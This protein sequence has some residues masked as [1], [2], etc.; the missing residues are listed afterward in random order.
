MNSHPKEVVSLWQR[1]LSKGWDGSN[2]LSWHIVVDL[3][4]FTQ[5]ETEGIYDLLQTLLGMVEA[6]RNMMGKVI[7]R[8]V[9]AS[10]K[11]DDL[12]WRHIISD[13]DSEDT[14]DVMSYS[15]KLHCESH[16]FHKE[17]FLHKRLIDSENFLDLVITTLKNWAMRDVN[18]SALHGLRSTFMYSSS[19]ERRH[20]RRDIHHAD[21][22]SILLNGVENA[23]KY[24]ARLNDRWWLVN[25]PKLRGFPE[26]TIRYFLTKAYIENP[27]LNVVGI[28]GILTDKEMLRYGHIDYEIGELIVAGYHYLNN[29]EQESH[30][31]LVLGL[32][33][34]EDWGEEGVP[35][36]A[37]H[38]IYEYLIWIPAIFRLSQTQ[39]LIEQ[40]QKQFGVSRPEPHIHSWG[41]MVGSPVSLS[42]LM[43]LSD[44]EFFRLLNYYNDYQERSNHPADHLTGGRDMVERTL[45][46]L[47]AYDPIRYYDLIPELIMQGFQSGYLI[48][49]LRG[50]AEH[51]RYRFSRLQPPQGWEAIKPAPDGLFLARALICLL[52]KYSELWDDGHAVARILEVCCEVVE[53][54]YDTNRIVFLLYR[55]LEYS[56]PEEDKQVTFTQGKEENSDNDLRHTAIN[57]IRGIGAGSAIRLCNRLIEQDKDIPELMLPLL[58]HCARDPVLAVR[59]ALLDHLA[60]LTYK[61]HL[62]GWQLFRD[63]FREPQTY[64]WPLVESHLYH[65]YYEHFNDV[66]PYLNRMR[67]EVPVEAANSWAR[68]ITLATL[69]GHLDRNELF[70]QLKSVN[71]MTAW[72]GAAQ[73]FVANLDRY[74]EDGLCIYGLSHL[75]SL[76]EQSEQ[77]YRSIGHVFDLKNHSQYIDMAFA[78]KYIDAM[79]SGGRHHDLYEF[80]DWI[81]DLTGRDPVAALTVCEYLVEKL[82]D[83]ESSNQLWRTEPLISAL[84]GI[85]READETEDETLIHRAVNLQDRFLRMD[86]R[87]IEDFFEQAGH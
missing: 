69:S 68:I 56:N 87:G 53:D 20:S 83:Q 46:D 45:S 71:T 19:W 29:H 49:L 82:S 9:E 30:Q 75:L 54:I 39:I 70:S 40:Y 50:I 5:W 25:E 47:A 4:K 21:G 57:S 73:V 15:H 51:L 60:Y 32:Y 59:A 38:N 14:P 77:L 85:L 27:E 55:L 63:I 17:Q 13:V 65:Q 42:N 86:I 12:L 44:S 23:F 81:A 79:K 41:G 18:Y 72:E 78:L 36:W 24:H 61:R 67:I 58:R 62:W 6:D 80:L 66:A 31:V 16:Q 76:D 2:N 11:G 37:V 8:F 48:H 52:E 64:L 7:S 10:D 33:D 43:E 22:L 74:S 28:A 1:A 26:E 35:K 84:S 3:N 34:G